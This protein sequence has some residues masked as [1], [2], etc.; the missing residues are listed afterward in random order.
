[1]TP[2][3]VLTPEQ[4]AELVKRAVQDALAEHQPSAPAPALFDR[5]GIAQRL[6]LGT[7]TVDRLRRDGMPCV[8]IGDSPRFELAECLAWI[9]GRNALS[10]GPR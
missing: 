10:E 7:T 8:F 5:T 9:R 2:L 4:L 3:V 6:G 1:M